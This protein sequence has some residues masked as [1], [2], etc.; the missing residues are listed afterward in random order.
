MDINGVIPDLKEGM[1]YYF[2]QR[3]LPCIFIISS[4]FSTLCRIIS[5]NEEYVMLDSQTFSLTCK[6][7]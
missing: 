3:K 1:P 4:F 5:I 7:T 2:R 6:V